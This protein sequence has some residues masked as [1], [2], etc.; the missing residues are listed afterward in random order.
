[1]QP[2]LMTPSGY[3][4]RPWAPDDASSLRESLSEAEAEQQLGA[5]LTGDRAT[6]WIAERHR[7]WVADRGY[8]WA[9]HDQDRG[10]IGAATVST[11]DRRHE[12]GWVSYWTGRSA[13]GRGVATEAVTALA[14]WALSEL[15]L[16]RLELGHRVNNPASCAV[17]TAAGFRAEGLE[18]AKLRYGDQRFDVELHARLATDPAP[19]PALAHDGRHGPTWA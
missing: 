12:T 10:L 2:E 4:M 5:V 9:I 1:M 15:G 14:G 6:E 13:R 19:A 7:E 3:L 11:V 8:S 18:R 17:A 16:F